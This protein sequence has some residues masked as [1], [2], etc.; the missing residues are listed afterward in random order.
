MGSGTQA[1]NRAWQIMSGASKY[2]HQH[3]V[4]CLRITVFQ[5]NRNE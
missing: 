1:Q 3:H 4:R 2:V 5:K